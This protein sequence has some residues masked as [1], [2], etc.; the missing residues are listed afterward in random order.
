VIKHHTS[1]NPEVIV[2]CCRSCHKKIHDRVRKEDACKYSPKETA[3]ISKRL[4]HKRVSKQISFYEEM[5]PGVRLMEQ[6]EL[7]L[8]N[9]NVYYTSFFTPYGRYNMHSE[10]I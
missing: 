5:M 4:H 10:E 1:Y 8:N 6:I 7:N 2:D 3:I 9:G